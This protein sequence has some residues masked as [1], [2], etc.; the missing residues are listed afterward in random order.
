MVI[1]VVCVFAVG[2]RHLELGDGSD[3][4]MDIY[5]TF[6]GY[7]FAVITVCQ[8]LDQL[9]GAWS[10]VLGSLCADVWMG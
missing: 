9:N 8:A 7:L 2:P 1:R 10:S 5:S 4:C 6:I 3:V